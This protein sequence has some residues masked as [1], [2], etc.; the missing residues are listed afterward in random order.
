VVRDCRVKT[1]RASSE[2]WSRGS[3]IA[4]FTQKDGQA[5]EFLTSNTQES[6]GGKNIFCLSRYS[7]LTDRCILM[8]EEAA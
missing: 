7:C 8:L 1:V 3:V 4:I 6:G 5:M 2:D